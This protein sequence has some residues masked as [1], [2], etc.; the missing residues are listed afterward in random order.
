MH[1]IFCVGFKLIPKYNF[2][3]IP[4]LDGPYNT[5]K[6]ALFRVEGK[7]KVEELTTLVK[8]SYDCYLF[9]ALLSI[10]YILI[11][12]ANEI[13]PIVVWSW[14]R[15]RLCF[16]DSGRLATQITRWH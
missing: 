7:G 12:G 11:H 1:T 5:L 13:G 4:Q 9:S 15:N 8:P 3:C 14:K 16:N 6:V 2:Q 10:I